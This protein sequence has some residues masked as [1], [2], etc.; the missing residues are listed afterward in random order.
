MSA[1]NNITSE[2]ASEYVL[3]SWRRNGIPWVSIH[4]LRSVM[5]LV[6]V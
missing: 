2:D 5:K 1:N 6:G 4:L 3:G